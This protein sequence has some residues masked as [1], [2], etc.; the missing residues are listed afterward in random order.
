LSAGGTIVASGKSVASLTS[1]D[2]SMLDLALARYTVNGQLDTSFNKTGTLLINLSISVATDSLSRPLAPFDATSDLMAAFMQLTQSDQGVI[3]VTAGGELLDVGNSGANTVEAAIVAEGL[4]LA[5]SFISSLPA[6]IIGGGKGT[7]TVN[8]AEAGTELA[9]GAFTIELFAS[10]TPSV[11]AGETPFQTV[12][13]K[14]KL[15]EGGAE[16]VKLKF[17]YPTSLATGSYYLIASID[18]GALRDLNAGNNSSA[19]ASTVLIAPP[20][21]QLNGSGLTAP[22]FDGAKPASVSFTI[23]NVGNET[24][25]ASAVQFFASTT[26][27]PTGGISLA[28]TPLK[29]NL[30]AGAGHLYKFK[31]ALPTTLPAGT[32]MLVALL[33]P[34][35]VFNDPN[36]A[37]NFI[38][39]GNTFV[40]A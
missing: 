2:P 13:A 38:V 4:D 17:K 30:K 33:D 39:S 29:L 10:T 36:S 27:T 7:A 24:A 28:T 20:F 32:Y 3:A 18:T 16:N 35:N 40:A 23:T 31:L 12:P 11:P 9:S 1:F 6:S 15:K 21:V 5:A 19:S 8:I 26:A 34:A 22:T 37:M 14:L 25:S